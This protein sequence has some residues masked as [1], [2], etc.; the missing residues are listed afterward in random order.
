MDWA[1]LR[2]SRTGRKQWSWGPKSWYRTIYRATPANIIRKLDVWNYVKFM[3]NKNIDQYRRTSIYVASSLD[4]DLLSKG[5]WQPE[6]EADDSWTKWAHS[7][8]QGLQ[9][10]SLAR[11]Y[12][13]S[14]ESLFE[15]MLSMKTS[16]STPFDSDL[17]RFACASSIISSIYYREIWSHHASTYG[18]CTR[19]SIYEM[20][21]IHHAWRYRSYR[22]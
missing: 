10:S 11:Y 7:Y 8:F 22:Y 1:K 3:P 12:L 4:G 9:D 6:C 13:D 5:T 20:E 2:K 18:D 21:I 17:Q 19:L 15:S 14:I 16:L